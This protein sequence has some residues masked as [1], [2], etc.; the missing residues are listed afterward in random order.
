MKTK[1]LLGILVVVV[2]VVA[3]LGYINYYAGEEEPEELMRVKV[4]LSWVHEA[5][6]AGLYWAD[7]KGFYEE[8]GLSVNLIPYQ[9]EDLAQELVDGKYDFVIMQTDTLI[10]A[11]EKG[12]KVKALFADYRLM[13]TCYFSKKKANITKP[14]H[15]AGK[16]VGVAYSERYPLV[17][18]L[19]NKG[20]NVSEVNIVE[21]EYNYKALA[22]DTFDV[23]AGWVTDGDFVEAAIGEYNV[24]HP[25]DYGVNWHA[26]LIVTTEEM[27]ENE[28]ELVEAFIRAT[29]K[30]WEQAIE[31]V[32]E[33]A[34]LTQKYDP[35]TEAE[36]LIFALEV[37][38]PL[39]HTGENQI[40]WMDESFFQNAQELLLDQ[41]VIQEPIKVQEI[42]TT[43]FLKK[44]S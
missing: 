35:E 25:Y 34:L 33:A 17:G 28:S 12:L 24:M 6:F 21:R 43:K 11:Q 41:D 38:I 27:I 7:Q 31:H 32:D 19:K 1:V 4:G 9:Y 18:M 23:E 26:D 14:E 20:I 30:G 22:D 16:T 36:H 40:G 15:L 5:Q 8:E 29:V 13:P 10:Q 39:I 44:V 2:L 37:S 42:Y 3:S